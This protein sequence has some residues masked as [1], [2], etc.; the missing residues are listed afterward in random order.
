MKINDDV[1]INLDQTKCT[2][3]AS[4]DLSAAFDTVDHAIFISRMKSLYNIKDVALAWF[5]SYLDNRDSR[6]CIE[7]SFSSISKVISGVPQ[8]SVLGA[9]LY[10]MYTRPLSDIVRKQNV[11][12]HSYADDTQIYL[13]CDHTQAALDNTISRLQ[14]CISDICIWMD[15]NALKLNTDKTEFIIF[16]PKSTII[17]EQ[18]LIISS[19]SVQ[20]S[21]HVKI[22]GVTLD[23]HMSLERYLTN[24]CRSANI[25]IRKIKSIRHYLSDD[26]VKTLVQSLVISRLDYCNSLL[27]GLPLKSIHCMQLVQNSAARVISTLVKNQKEMSIQDTHYDIQIATQ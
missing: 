20:E 21:T 12:F 23:Q 15:N 4:L 7:D 11:V 14:Q 24:T 25:H 27:I 16:R 17:D 9:R 22:L 6:V 10:T 18:H 8:G 2:V 5:T 19:S 13:H 3:L 1:L 26:A